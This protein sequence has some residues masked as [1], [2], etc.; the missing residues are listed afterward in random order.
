MQNKHYHTVAQAIQYINRNLHHQP[1]L[2]DIANAVNLSPYHFQRVFRDWAGVSPKRFLQY[3]TI[4]HAKLLLKNSS[5]LD[6]SL[7]TGLSSQS[8]LHDHFV[9]L[10]A[11][12]PG[13]YK[14]DGQG[15]DIDYGFTESPFGSVCIATTELGI[16]HLGFVNDKDLKTATLHLSKIWPNARLS[17]NDSRIDAL[18]KKIF[19]VNSTSPEKFHLLVKGSNF[20][21]KVWESLLSIPEG[22]IQSYQQIAKAIAQPKASRAVANAIAKN[23]IGYLIPCHRVIR[24]TGVISGYRWGTERKQALIAWESARVFKTKGDH[25]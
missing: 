19:S 24:S 12:T 2:H 20:Q 13:Q 22:N 11:I 16:C 7:Q 10:E 25:P 21:I 9:T 1:E 14:H 4:Q 23:P 5:L 8:R 6:T 17:H 18:G 3:L 15:L